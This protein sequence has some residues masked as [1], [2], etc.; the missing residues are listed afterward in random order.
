MT[1]RASMR[2]LRTTT[3]LDAAA[4]LVGRSMCSNP[5]NERAFG[6]DSARREHALVRFFVPVLRGATARGSLVMGA[7]LDAN[8]AGVYVAAPP[9]RCQPTLRDK[10]RVFPTVLWGTPIA[11]S[12][13]VATWTAAWARADPTMSHWHLGPMAVAV[14]LQGQGIGSAMLADFCARIDERSAVSYLETD[15]PENVRLYKKWAFAVVAEAQVIGVTTWFM[16]RPART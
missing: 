8:L 6:M 10:V 13:R 16:S 15:K 12:A 4:A 5:I 3:E 9:G 7:F 2:E 14:G 1:S 11:T